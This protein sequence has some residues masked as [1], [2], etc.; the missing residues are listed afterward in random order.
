M[1]TRTFKTKASLL[2]SILLLSLGSFSLVS[3]GLLSNA[4]GL[5]LMKLQFGCLPEGTLID[6][7]DGA[8]PI[9]ELKAGDRVIGYGGEVVVV[10]QRHEYLEDATQV[11]HLKVIFEGGEEV[12]LSP[13]HRIG[14]IPARELKAGAKVGDRIVD[15]VERL[16][17]VSRS[18]DLLTEDAGYQIQGVPV[19]SMIREMALSSGAKRQ[20][21]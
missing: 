20:S 6:G 10:Q 13:R 3:C 18:Y 17:G 1:M 4:V 11:R 14:G 8:V 15:R 21:R 12:A 2:V 7:P 19:N 5:G 16:G 9:E